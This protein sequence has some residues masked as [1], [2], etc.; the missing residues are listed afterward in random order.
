MRKYQAAIINWFDLD[1][2]GARDVM[3][4]LNENPSL[5]RWWEFHPKDPFKWD[6]LT[7]RNEGSDRHWLQLKL[8]G[9][10]GNREAIGA[11]VTVTTPEGKQTQEVGSGDGAFF[12]Q[13]HYR[14]YFGLGDHAEADSVEIL[15]SDGD[16]QRIEDVQADQLLVISRESGTQDQD[17]PD[18]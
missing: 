13:G 2:D 15:W 16:L 3:I 17:I 10:R 18:G 9:N 5:R 11:R 14:L 1:N 12:S 8:K 4:T 7:Y 6:I